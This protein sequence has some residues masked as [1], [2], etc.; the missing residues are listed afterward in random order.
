MASTFG[1]Q[2][3]ADQSACLRPEVRQPRLGANPPL[4]VASAILQPRLVEH[5]PREHLER[6]KTAWQSARRTAV[7]W[8]TAILPFGAPIETRLCR[9]PILRQRNFRKTYGKKKR[10]PPGNCRPL[11][12]IDQHF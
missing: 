9:R 11:A 6:H 1:L 3:Q 8:V 4:S 7:K 12:L 10:S 5:C 2:L